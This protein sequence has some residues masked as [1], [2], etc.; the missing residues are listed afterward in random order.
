VLGAFGGAI[1]LVDRLRRRAEEGPRPRRSA[2]ALPTVPVWVALAFSL[3]AFAPV[4]TWLYAEYTESIWADP[5]G[6]FVA[7]F[8]ILLGRHRLRDDPDPTPQA[9]AWGFA[10][11][12]P[13]C[14]LAVLDAGIRSH[15]IGL[16]GLLL[17]LPGLALLLLGTPRTRYLAFPLAVCLFLIPL[18]DGLGDPFF[19]PTLTSQIGVAITRAVGIP[20]ALVDTRIELANGVGIE[21]GQN[22]SGLSY[23][24]SGCAL[25]FVCL[26]VTR[27]WPRRL[28]L[29]AAPYLLAALGNGLRVALLLL[30][31]GTIGLEWKLTTPFHGMVG[32]GI[33]LLVMA[34][35]WLVSD[36]R[37]LREALS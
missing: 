17:A 9:S 36:R 26:G 19:L 24:Y 5:H 14:A 16:L 30:V 25:A 7:L 22:C 20:V 8:A 28:A 33:F 37:A 23:F 35:I 18:P 11:L 29:V 31:G 13:G 2:I 32:S 34:G 12:I 27:S 6:L 21:V 4:L 1:V 10:L 3:A 15:Y